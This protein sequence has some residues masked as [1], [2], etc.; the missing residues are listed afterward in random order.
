MDSGLQ[1]GAVTSWKDFVAAA[2]DRTT[3]TAVAAHAADLAS[4]PLAGRAALWLGEGGMTYG[5]FNRG[6]KEGGSWLRLYGGGLSY[7]ENLGCAASNGARVF[8]RQ[9]LSNFINGTK[10]GQPRGSTTDSFMYSPQPAWWVAVL[11]K[12]LIGTRAFGV[13]VSLNSDGPVHAF[14]FDAKAAA[15][16]DA[17]AATTVLVLTNW[18]FEAQQ[19]LV[20]G[21]VHDAHLYAIA[22]AGQIRGGGKIEA[23]SVGIAV[24]GREARVDQ[25]GTIPQGALAPVPLHCKA[26]QMELELAGLTGAFVAW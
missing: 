26:G 19:V 7:L 15:P 25:D 20:N 12:R 1:P 24:N 3:C 5:G 6:D 4:S 17:D 9:Q 21:C 14:A 8:M 16:T 11:W 13:T 2:R 18:G 10:L 22:P 23:D